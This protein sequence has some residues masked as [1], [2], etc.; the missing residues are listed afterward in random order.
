MLF[1]RSVHRRSPWVMGSFLLLFVLT[2]CGQ[3]APVQL[4]VTPHEVPQP[5]STPTI[6]PPSPNSQASLAQRPLTVWIPSSLSGIA[7]P[8]V[9]SVIALATDTFSHRYPNQPVE[10][11]VKAEGGQASLLNYLRN[12]QRVAPTILPD[13]LLLDAQ[14]IWQVAELGL[15]QPVTVTELNEREDFYPFAW[16]AVM[17]HDRY[18]GIPYFTAPLHLVYNSQMVEEPPSTWSELVESGKRFAFAGAGSGGLADEWLLHQY[19]SAGGEIGRG[20]TVNPEAIALLAAAIEQGRTAGTIPSEVMIY[21]SDSAVWSALVAGNVELASIPATIYL[22]ERGAGAGAPV[23]AAPLPILHGE[24]PT[25]AIVYAF[26]VLAEDSE[27]RTQAL[28]L[29]DLLLAPEV[30]GGW[31]QEVDWLP[32]RPAALQARVGQDGYLQFLQQLLE[33]ATALPVDRAF[34]DFSRRLQQVISAVMSSEMTPEAAA[35]A[36]E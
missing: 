4:T 10:W 35:A 32:V 22:H 14:Q 17:M 28:A 9:E 15:A 21:S 23:A 29:V 6:S 2:A 11:V 26:I 34:A 24:V 16:D 12:A 7:R 3:A 20:M 19:L 1:N 18:Y 5:T 31:A 36:F 25:V 13:L 27:R 33:E 8:R 30:H